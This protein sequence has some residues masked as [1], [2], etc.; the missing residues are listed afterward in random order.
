[1]SSC[2]SFLTALSQNASL[3]PIILSHIFQSYPC[4]LFLFFPNLLCFD[5]LIYS[6]ALFCSKSTYPTIHCTPRHGCSTGISNPA[7]PNSLSSPL[8]LLLLGFL[9]QLIISL[10]IQ[11]LDL[12]TTES[13][14]WWMVLHCTII[15]DVIHAVASV[16]GANVVQCITCITEHGSPPNSSIISMVSHSLILY[17]SKELVDNSQFTRGPHLNIHDTLSQ[18]DL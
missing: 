8:N 3:A 16:N 15:R 4:K 2:G 7:C 1:M 9:S 10:S 6:P 5:D 12:E 13:R 18:F 11:S 17:N 14:M